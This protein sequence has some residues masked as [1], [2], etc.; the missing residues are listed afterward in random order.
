[1]DGALDDRHG[2]GGA[3][4]VPSRPGRVVPVGA[5]PATAA[6]DIDLL[7]DDLFGEDDGRPPSLA[8]YL[9]VGAGACGVAAALLL[10]LPGVVLVAAAA[11]LAIG[12]ILPLRSLGRAVTGRLHRRR[13]TELS[14]DGM[15]LRTGSAPVRRLLAGF[16]RLAT[17]AD[18]QRGPLT[19]EAF[20]AGHALV[21]EVA[22]LLAG[23]DPAHDELA[24]VAV[25]AAEVEA[26]IGELARNGGTDAAQRAARRAALAEID[27]VDGSSPLDAARRL[28]DRMSGDR[29]A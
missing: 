2:A 11:M 16:E 8:D 4:L 10:D 24:F 5:T 18:A 9:L 29:P 25:R 21:R 26:L 14:G 13:A 12:A 17:V 28:R 23:R 7:L 22:V 27:A 3:V 19:A 15:V 6:D 1:M 20:A